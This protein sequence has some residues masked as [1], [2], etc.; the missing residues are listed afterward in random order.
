MIDRRPGSAAYAARWAKSVN[1]ALE[2]VTRP[3]GSCDNCGDAIT[4]D[5]DQTLCPKVPEAVMHRIAMILAR[6]AA[7]AHG[8][9]QN[10]RVAIASS[11]RFAQ[12]LRKARKNTAPSAVVSWA[13]SARE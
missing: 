10:T 11:T 3:F 1:K 13:R 7:F 6:E 12:T 5:A 2:A 8:A 9:R 4:D